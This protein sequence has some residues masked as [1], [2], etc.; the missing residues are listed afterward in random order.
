MK[1]TRAMSDVL[2][3]GPGDQPVGGRAPHDRIPPAQRDPAGRRR[4]R[5][6][7]RTAGP[8]RRRCRRTT[9]GRCRRPVGRPVP[10]ARPLVDRHDAPTPWRRRRRA[11]PR[12]PPPA[13]AW[14]STTSSSP[15][16]GGERR[17]ARRSAR[18]QRGRHGAPRG[19]PLA[20][21]AP[22]GPG[23]RPARSTPT[24]PRSRTLPS[25]PPRLFERFNGSLATPSL[26]RSGAG[27]RYLAARP[28]S[29]RG[30]SP[31]GRSPSRILPG[32][33]CRNSRTAAGCPVT[34][35]MPM[36]MPMLT[37]T[38]NTSTPATPGRDQRP[39]HVLATGGRCGRPAR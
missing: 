19:E 14:S 26:P 17:P 4:P 2:R 3:R 36:V 20:G 7:A 15:G 12:P 24:R 23:R 10:G 35:M 29:A 27:G 28:P 8:S 16:A 13:R 30:R 37:N 31:T 33:C 9:A 25:A 32:N 6:T 38:W 1:K 34:G 11:R 22:P 18:P 39:V 5:R 21:P